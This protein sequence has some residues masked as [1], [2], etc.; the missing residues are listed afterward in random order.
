MSTSV[1]WMQYYAVGWLNVTIVGGNRAKCTSDL[2]A[3]FH[4]TARESLISQNFLFPNNK[5]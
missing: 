3:L 5:C 2:A 1:F 4:E